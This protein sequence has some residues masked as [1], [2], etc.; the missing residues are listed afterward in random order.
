[1]IGAKI[2]ESVL[3]KCIERILIQVTLYD[4]SGN[5]TTLNSTPYRTDL[6]II[7]DIA[8]KSITEE[9]D[10]ASPWGSGE[11]QEVSIFGNVISTDKTS[12]TV[13]VHKEDFPNISKILLDILTEKMTA[14]NFSVKC[15]GA[16]SNVVTISEEVIDRCFRLY[17][18]IVKISSIVPL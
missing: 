1:M 7:F 16:F 11:K 13:I 8:S 5:I 17:S 15:N 9:Y 2:A 12:K 4:S 18:Q 14:L 6:S 3:T 10:D